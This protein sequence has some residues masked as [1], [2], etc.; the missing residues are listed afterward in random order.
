[1]TQRQADSDPREPDLVIAVLTF[2]RPDLLRALL[3]ALISQARDL[4]IRAS[5]LVVDNDEHASGLPVVADFKDETVRGVHETRAG[6]AAAR[7]RALHEAAGSRYLVFIDDDERPSDQWLQLLVDTAIETNSAGVVGPV[8]P[9]YLGEPGEWISAGRFF[10]HDRH[11]T[12]ARMSAAATNNLLLDL[13]VVRSLGLHFDEEFSKSG[14]SDTLFTRRMVAGGHEIVWC[15]EATVYD[16]VPTHRLTR[17]W[18]L[19]RAFRAGNSWSRVAL[20]LRDGRP[21]LPT[22]LYQS[23]RGVARILAGAGRWALGVVMRRRDHEARGARTLVR[24]AGYLLGA[25]GYVYHE[26]SR[27]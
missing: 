17:R 1:M 11:S 2:R 13:S 9:E 16:Q 22:R 3:P 8:L 20:A 25:W 26:Y 23:V 10:E 5:V 15:D 4:S 18:V 6:I 27:R 14:G 21:R 12:G 24:G 19:Q 7:N